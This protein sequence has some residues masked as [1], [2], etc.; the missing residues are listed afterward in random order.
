MFKLFLRVLIFVIVSF[1]FPFYELKRRRW[2]FLG[3]DSPNKSTTSV[4]KGST[5]RGLYGSRATDAVA[6]CPVV[7]A[8]QQK[9]SILDELIRKGMIPSRLP[10]EFSMKSPIWTRKIKKFCQIKTKKFA[11]NRTFQSRTKMTYLAPPL[12]WEFN[13][14]LRGR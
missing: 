8:G 7:F 10:S 5:P 12:H 4:L 9:W 1:Y 14:S 6:G 2:S 11:E 13:M 3:R